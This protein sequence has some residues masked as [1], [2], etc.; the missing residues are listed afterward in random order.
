MEANDRDHLLSHQHVA[1]GVTQG[2]IL[3]GDN[4]RKRRVATTRNLQSRQADKAQRTAQSDGH[5]LTI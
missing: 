2:V 4:K 5:S 1:Q 3:I